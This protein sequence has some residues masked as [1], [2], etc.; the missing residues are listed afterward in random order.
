VSLLA[1]LS[2]LGGRC[3]PADSGS[4]PSVDLQPL[5]NSVVGLDEAYVT[6]RPEPTD[7]VNV[8]ARAGLFFPPAS[9]EHDGPDWSLSR[10]LTPSAINSWIAEEVKVAGVEATLH[11]ALAS[12]PVSLTLAA[13]EGDETAGALLAYRGW[14]LH[15]LR[16]TEASRV[17]RLS[18]PN[19]SQPPVTG[20]QATPEQAECRL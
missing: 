6:Y 20:A 17:A 3:C 14:A 11:T 13:F 12:R 16:A 1:A 19:S 10:T 4:W 9:L 5:A 18:E 8:S 7:A 15:D 2:P